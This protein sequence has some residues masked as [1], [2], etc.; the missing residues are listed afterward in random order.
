[1]LSLM[2]CSAAPQI[3]RRK[4]K[5]LK[6]NFFKHPCPSGLKTVAQKKGAENGNNAEV[7]GTVNR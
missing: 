5:V 2:C 4:N 3:R 6:L 1:M 7:Q